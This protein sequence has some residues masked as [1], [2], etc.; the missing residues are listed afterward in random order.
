MTS[1]II[2]NDVADSIRS[3]DEKLSSRN[4]SL[5]PRGYFIIKLNHQKKEI[6]LEHYDNNIDHLGRAIDINTGKPIGCHD[7]P[8]RTPSKT[9][10]GKSAKEIG[11][12]IT[13][14]QKDLL[15]SKLDHSLYLGRELQR[16]QECL[17]NGSEYKQD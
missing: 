17:I 13:E 16:A 5:D 7:A 11:I 9:F 1:R 4:I 2:N 8:I 15:I 12:Q 14:R 6:I 3:L 10:T